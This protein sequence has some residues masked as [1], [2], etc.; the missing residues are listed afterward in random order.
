LSKVEVVHSVG[1]TPDGKTISED[2]YVDPETLKVLRID[3]T[4]REIID[5]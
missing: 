4:T 3:R 1:R 2:L 5:M